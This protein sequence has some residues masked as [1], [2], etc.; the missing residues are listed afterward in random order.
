[1]ALAGRQPGGVARAPCCCARVRRENINEQA[2]SENDIMVNG[3]KRSALC[4]RCAGT[5]RFIRDG[6]EK[7]ISAKKYLLCAGVAH[8]TPPPPP[9]RLLL[10][11]IA[12]FVFAHLAHKH[13]RQRKRVHAPRR[14]VAGGGRCIACAARR[15]ER[16]WHRRRRQ[17]VSRGVAVERQRGWA[18]FSWH[19]RHVGGKRVAQSETNAI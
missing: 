4:A 1:M 15:G 10:S 6:R 14:Q 19:E 8:K 7:R 13:G 16:R 12:A 5:P 3:K 9:P 17:A 2:S 11:R 18:W